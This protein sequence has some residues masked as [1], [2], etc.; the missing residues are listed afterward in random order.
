MPASSVSGYLFSHP[1]SKYF[2]ILSIGD[3]QL[4][5]YANRN[6]MSLDEAKKW[7]RTVHINS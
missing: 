2:N 3:D 6:G 7:L 5:S 1:N 4:E